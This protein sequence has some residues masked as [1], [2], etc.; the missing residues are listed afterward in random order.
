M[1]KICIT[2]PVFINKQEHKQYLDQT[3]VSIHSD[4]NEI[5]FVPVENYVTP[6]LIPISYVFRQEPSEIRILGGG[7]NQSV[8]NA[9][10]MG[11]EEGILH[12]CKYILVIN[13]DIVMKA[14]AIDRLV[15]FAD[16]QP[17]AVM[18]TMGEWADLGTLDA[19]PEDENYSEHPHFSCYMVRH[20]F[21][22]HVG[23]FDTNFVPAYLEDN[24]MVA[25]LALAHKKA[26]VYGGARFYHYGSRTIK[27]DNEQW[28]KNSVTF[29]KNQQYFL[30]KWGHPVVGEPDEMRAKYYSTPYN[31]GKPLSY[32]R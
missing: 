1:A 29:P 32:S 17:E 16:S 15:D 9:W 23:K 6:S 5:M 8:A 7:S 2:V 22:T 3:T 30:S 24:D 12:D 28:R 10:N 27:S 14:N 26:Y 18:W 4:K 11:I 19:A 25:R 20:D 13:S 31:T 21:F